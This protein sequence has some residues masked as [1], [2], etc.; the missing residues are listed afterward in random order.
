MEIAYM[1]MQSGVIEYGLDADS[2][3]IM[4]KGRGANYM[5]RM[6]ELKKRK[7]DEDAEQNRGDEDDE[8][9]KTNIVAETPTPPP[10]PTPSCRWPG[11]EA[12]EQACGSNVR[13]ETNI[14]AKTPTPPPGPPPSHLWP[15]NKAQEQA[16]RSKVRHEP[17]IVAKTPTPPCPPVN[18]AMPLRLRSNA[19]LQQSTRPTTPKL[20]MIGTILAE[21]NNK[22]YASNPQD[23]S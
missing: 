8:D 16:C 9:G 19:V 15:G 10:Y 17:Y 18:E 21:A 1:K 12:Q 4:W 23:A 22:Y 6:A 5:E 11:S 20:T 3:E 7:R 2:V 13:H 14:V